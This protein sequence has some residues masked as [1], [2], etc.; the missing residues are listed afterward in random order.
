MERAAPADRRV[1]GVDPGTRQLGWG[2]V[3]A[4]G[5]AFRSLGHGVL[6]ADAR[7]DMATR[8]ASL[9]KGLREV[10][11]R[12]AP[13]EAA[14]EEAFHGRNVQAAL[15]LGE[16]RG[17]AL[18]VLAEAGLPVSGYANNVVKRSVTGG[19]RATKERVRAMVIRLLGLDEAPETLDASDAL[20]L[21]LCH[22]QRR[23]WPGGGTGGPSAR[24]A[25]AVRRARRGS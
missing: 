7:E 24:I 12:Y 22:H 14:I 18:L 20:A 8:L 4:R 1:L 25:E 6:R 9:A 21:A 16:G 17:A 10:M 23:A 3:E 19:G 11:A 15:R 5:R 13:S 2:V